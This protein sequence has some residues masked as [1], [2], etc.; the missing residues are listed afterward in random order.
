MRGRRILALYCAG[1]LA[2]TGARA[3]SPLMREATPRLETQAQPPAQSPLMREAASLAQP[4]SPTAAPSPTIVYKDDSLVEK[5]LGRLGWVLLGLGIVAA[6]VTL[7]R[8]RI[9]GV[10]AA[11]GGRRLRVV[12]MVRVSPRQALLLVEVD[13]RSLL[14]AMNG[15]ELTVLMPPR[16]ARLEQPP[17]LPVGEALP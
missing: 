16:E 4:A 17:V 10:R 1:L 15:N 9:Q 12:E 3:E 13:R 8:K 5:S 2:A 7:G 6:A 11:A 14:V